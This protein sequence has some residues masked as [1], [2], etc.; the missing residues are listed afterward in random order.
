MTDRNQNF[1]PNLSG[2]ERERQKRI[3][4]EILE[5]TGHK[6]KSTENPQVDSALEHLQRI[7]RDVLLM[8]QRYYQEH[9]LGT[10]PVK[11]RNL[12]IQIY[13]D[14]LSKWSKDDLLCM[15]AMQQTAGAMHALGY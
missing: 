15:F 9:P 3:V 6:I 7:K 5:Q 8:V 1:R 13:I 2:E 12:I 10:D 4:D 14:E 11:L